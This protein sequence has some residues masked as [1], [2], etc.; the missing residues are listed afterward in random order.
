[1]FFMTFVRDPLYSKG[2]DVL[3]DEGP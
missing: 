1:V 3:E 2:D